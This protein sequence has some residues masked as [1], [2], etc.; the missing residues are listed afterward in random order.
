MGFKLRSTSSHNQR[1]LSL[2]VSL[3]I[4]SSWKHCI[5][6]QRLIDKQNA[7]MKRK[8]V[9]DEREKC[10]CAVRT[11]SWVTFMLQLNFFFSKCKHALKQRQ[12]C[13][14]T[15]FCRQQ[16][17]DVYK[18]TTFNE[19]EQLSLSKLVIF[20]WSADKWTTMFV[21]YFCAF[22][23]WDEWKSSVWCECKCEKMIK[24]TKE[25]YVNVN[26]VCLCWVNVLTFMLIHWNRRC[27]KM[28]YHNRYE[29]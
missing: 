10:V 7:F 3:C 5:N 15:F 2:G 13:V 29:L 6:V 12:P 16:W 18:T 28:G 8:H 17:T 25:Y 20:F 14:L 24:E 23:K 1:C 26:C 9:F 22:I 27:R 4:F 19:Y 11:Y 21:L